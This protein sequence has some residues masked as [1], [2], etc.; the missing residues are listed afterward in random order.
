[1]SKIKTTIKSTILFAFTVTFYIKVQAQKKSDSIPKGTIVVGFDESVFPAIEVTS[2]SGEGNVIFRPSTQSILYVGYNREMLKRIDVEFDGGLGFQT[3]N[4]KY[5]TIGKQRFLNPQFYARFIGA[6][7]L[8]NKSNQ[9]LALLLGG[10]L[11]LSLGGKFSS[12]HTVVDYNQSSVVSST[13]SYV[14]GSFEK[15]QGYGTLGLRYSHSLKNQDLLLLSLK[16][17]LCFSKVIQGTYSLSDKASIGRF[18]SYRPQLQLGIAYQFTRLAHYL[19]IER[20]TVLEGQPRKVISG[21][22]R[23]KKRYYDPESWFV[24]LS[25]GYFWML[26]QEKGGQNLFESVYK[27][28]GQWQITVEKGI[29]KNF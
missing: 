5:G 15:F 29:G 19:E 14:V 20:R 23:K 28:K 16:S 4:F 12:S 1:M 9:Q 26:T 27:N 24:E 6:Y 10:G 22:V 7:S 11:N 25:G 17:N 3:V 8:T 2:S 18:E 21:E 13:F